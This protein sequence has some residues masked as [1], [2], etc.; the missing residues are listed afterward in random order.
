MP[1]LKTTMP[2][3]SA[4]DAMDAKRVRRVCDGCEEFDARGFD[5]KWT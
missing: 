5:L 3:M 2:A 1:I 4:M